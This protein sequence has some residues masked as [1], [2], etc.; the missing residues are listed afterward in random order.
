MKKKR[1]TGRRG[2]SGRE[3]GRKWNSK[4]YK[5]GMEEGEERERD[6]GGITRPY[7]TLLDH[8]PRHPRSEQALMRRH[9]S[10]RTNSLENRQKGRG[11][12][13][14]TVASSSS[15]PPLSPLLSSPLLLEK[16]LRF[17]ADCLLWRVQDETSSLARGSLN[18]PNGS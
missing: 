9:A 7:L 8:L 16:L 2:V 14:R 1:G 5:M 13:S 6:R 18:N 3:K 4:K 12:S 15:P 10:L 17:A 11:N